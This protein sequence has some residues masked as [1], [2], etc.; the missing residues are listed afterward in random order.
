MPSAATSDEAG[1]FES[2]METSLAVLQMRPALLASAHGPSVQDQLD[3]AEVCLSANLPSAA[4]LLFEAAFVHQGFSRQ[5]LAAQSRIAAR[6]GLWPGTS[7]A[8]DCGPAHAGTVGIAIA[9]MRALARAVGGRMA[10]AMASRQ[11]RDNTEPSPHS[12]SM[13]LQ[14][15]ANSSV[16]GDLEQ[17]LHALFIWLRGEAVPG[18]WGTPEALI[19][20]LT[21]LTRRSPAFDHRWFASAS[22]PLLAS[23]VAFASLREFLLANRDLMAEPLGSP[24]LLRCAAGLDSSGLGP[25]FSN[26]QRL[27]RKSRDVSELAYVAVDA[28][29]AEGVAIG[30]EPWI[31][32]LSRSCAT[33]L[34]SEIIDDLGD[35]NALPALSILFDRA[36]SLPD[37]RIDLSLITRL[38]DTALDCLD[39]DLASRAQ[40][41]VVR[42]KPAALQELLMLGDIDGTAGRI[43]A[44]EQSFVAY[45]EFVP[46]DENATERLM[47]LRSRKFSPFRIARGSGTPHERRL[48]R[49]RQKLGTS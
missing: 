31:A 38:R 33:A 25:Y 23:A 42:L 30:P 29:A 26:V 10:R 2:S 15:S 16:P 35:R 3:L 20:F 7:V 49:S 4:R 5:M 1:H 45:L 14:A 46:G 18:R 40:A 28:A 8:A 19:T 44:A 22:L 9:D 36:A 47:A 41:V 37:N 11:R 43:N 13:S 32:L 48:N 27:A 6:T 34:L 21:G 24:E 12:T 17:A 39:Y